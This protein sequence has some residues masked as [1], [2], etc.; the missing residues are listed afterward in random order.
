MKY[1]ISDKK[2]ANVI[3]ESAS[4]AAIQ[5]FLIYS[6]LLNY[7]IVAVCFLVFRFV[8]SWLYQLHSRWFSVS[9]E[10]FDVI[11]Y[12]GMAVYKVGILYYLT[13][14]HIWLYA[15]MQLRQC[16]IRNRP[17]QDAA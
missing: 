10:T 6:T 5:S 1:F 16:A 7:S 15:L 11:R 14:P 17:K 2:A 8:H 3:Q 13:L 9:A 4:V 12:A